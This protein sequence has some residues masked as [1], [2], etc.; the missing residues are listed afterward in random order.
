MFIFHGNLRNAVYVPRRRLFT[1]SARR[2]MNEQAGNFQRKLKLQ[3]A[4]LKENII[5][6]LPTCNTKERAR[7]K[8]NQ[9]RRLSTL[10][11][12]TFAP[13]ICTLAL[14]FAFGWMY[15]SRSAVKANAGRHP[16]TRGL[17]KR[18]RRRSEN[19]EEQFQTRN[20]CCTPRL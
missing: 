8:S 1:L 11:C 17:V 12:I 2:V 13:N 18:R 5:F 10:G 14:A 20:P 15:M 4:Q 9:L 3:P 7:E 6:F 16:G 19:L